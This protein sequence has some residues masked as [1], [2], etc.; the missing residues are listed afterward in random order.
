[1]FNKL[2]LA[3]GFGAGYVLGAKAG[4]QRYDQIQAKFKEFA[5]KPA[6]QDATAQVKATA[7]DLAGTAKAKASETVD[8]VSGKVDAATAPPAEPTIDLSAPVGVKPVTTPARPVTPPPP[9]VSTTT[10]PRTTSSPVPPVP[11]VTS[12]STTPKTTP[13]PSTRPGA[14]PSGSAPDVTR[15]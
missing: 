14:G 8:A 5:G 4:K 15:P 9:P 13:T 12:T 2:T 10:A 6:V 7:T 11:P 1:M 3:V